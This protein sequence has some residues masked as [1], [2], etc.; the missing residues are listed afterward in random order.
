MEGSSRRKQ[1]VADVGV[2]VGAPAFRDLGGR[3][4]RNG[5]LVRNGRVYRSCSLVE[6][7]EEDVEVLR[8]SIGLK[9]VVDLR[10][11]RETELD[12]DGPISALG[13]DYRRVPLVDLLIVGPPPRTED[14]EL[15]R[16]S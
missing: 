8:T 15:P 16:S 3:Q 10:D 13:L 2:L 4:G 9:T 5:R 6:A 1:Q 14:G 11:R 12:G 7:S